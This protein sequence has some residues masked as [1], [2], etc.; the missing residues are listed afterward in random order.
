MCISF[1][2]ASAA[3][4]FGAACC[5]VQADVMEVVSGGGSD[6]AIAFPDGEVDAAQVRAAADALQA[7]VEFVSPAGE[8]PANTAA[9][10]F[11]KTERNSAAVRRAIWRVTGQGVFEAYVNGVRVGEDFLKP[12]FTESGKCRHVYSYDITGLL[13]RGV[14][15]ENVFSATVAPGWWCDAMM[16]SVRETPWQLGRK[17]AFRGEL[18]LEYADGMQET[19]GTDKSWRAAYTGPV[20]SAGIYEGETYDARRKVEGLAPVEIN[21]E[22]CGELREAA[23]KIAL[24]HDIE[25][26]PSQMYVV[27]GAEGAS[28]NAFGKARIVRRYA[29]GDAVKLGAGELLV[30]D[31]GQNAAAVPSFSVSGDAGSSVVVRHAEML[32]DSNGEKGRGN[33]GPAGTPYLASLRSA[34]AELVYTLADGPNGFMPRH[35]FFGY[36]YLA[37]T[38]TARVVFSSFRSVP[39]SS[40]TAAMERGSVVTGNAR[41]NRLIENIRWGV[42][43]NYL[44]IPTDC[45]Q[46]DERMGW[47]ADT[48]V[49]MNSAAYLI[50]TYAFLSKYMADM[51]DAQYA[52][53]LYPCFVPNLRHVFRHW[54]SAG[55][56]DAGV[57]IPY[58]L[59]RWYGKREILD[60]NWDSMSRY[61]HFLESHEEPYRINHGDWLAFEHTLKKKDG[62]NQEAT[63]PRQVHLLN[64]AFRVWM[65]SLMGKMAEAKG[66][67][68]AVRH[69]ADE[70]AKHRALFAGRYLGDDGCLR[71]EY[72]GQCNDLYMLKLGLCG[73]PAAVEATKR[74][75]VENVRAHGN[76]LQTGFLGTPLLLPVLTFEAENPELA[77]TLLLQ[78]RF[79]SWLYSVD[80]GATTVWERWNGYT[81]EK[82][83]GPVSMNSFNH[84]AYGCVLEWLFS[85]V[86]GIR[87]A[88]SSVGYRHIVLQPFP[89]RRI[90]FAKAHYDSPSGR[91]ESCW[92]Y[93]KDGSWRWRFTIPEGAAAMVFMPGE[94]TGSAYDPG[95]YD[96]KR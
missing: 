69:Y 46:R 42:L 59:W 24:R 35:T 18:S 32:N 43:S 27:A 1:R 89:D 84:Y 41:V 88:K 86:A 6:S 77:Y 92:R 5:A 34:K 63:D 7:A 91:I 96:V 49:F 21:R 50:D 31:F 39:V 10:V 47:T 12:G 62:T 55:W 40:V 45:P 75:L 71:P 83:F 3:L 48:Q 52:D 65:A 72:R 78:D 28:S 80:Q 64:V 90:G 8:P 37:V 58:R 54:A 82:G 16:T 36:R 95:T 74:D 79:P 30:V 85:A 33:D 17:I 20:V 66:L 26:K 51:R 70:E 2:G 57:I 29:D 61:M 93:E 9:A 13:K 53:G 60:R 94:K 73:N 76:R 67:P 4:A 56:T 25:L 15:D 38:S 87:Q 11:E 19:R 68:D 22:F 44:S 23:A 81:K 14:G